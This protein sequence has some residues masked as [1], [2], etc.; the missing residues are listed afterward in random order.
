M[1]SI[2][3]YQSTIMEVHSGGKISKVMNALRSGVHLKKRPHI[4]NLVK[5]SLR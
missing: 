1:L 2:W 4:L 5:R 3:G